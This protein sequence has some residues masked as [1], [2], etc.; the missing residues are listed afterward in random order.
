MSD[1][2]KIIEERGYLKQGTNIDGLKSLMNKESITAYTGFDCTAKSL[3]VGSLVQI[4]MLRILQ[5][6]GHKPII[7]M[8]GGTTKIG[9]PSDKATERK[10]LTTDDINANKNSLSK[11]FKKFIKF[12]DDATDAVMVD[13][14][15]W[16]DKINYIDFLRD[17]GRH[18]SI[19][20]MLTLESVKRR[21]D[22]EQNLSFLEFNYLLLQSYDFVELN[23][24]HN[25]QLQFGGS[26]QWSNII[27][28]I[29]LSRRL[30]GKELYGLTSH[31]I[32]TSSGAKMGEN[33]RWRCLVT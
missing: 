32:T 25:C 6:C 10:M 29:E 9:D 2:L 4:M 11:I 31:L 21:L 22:R 7:L 26:E 23:K 1:F 12:G 3:H 33:C 17:Y 30:G 8:G 5:Q 28:G 15:Q 14:A 20:R 27:G 18:F 19:N 24:R 16:L 13:N